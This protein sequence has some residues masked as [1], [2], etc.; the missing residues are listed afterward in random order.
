MPS[1]DVA[2]DTMASNGAK[3]IYPKVCHIYGVLFWVSIFM[4]VS[5]FI[6]YNQP[7]SCI[8]D[9]TRLVFLHPK[10]CG[11]LLVALEASV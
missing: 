1:L 11:G 9:E 5:L 8:R 3:I 10:D 2:I 4:Y 7:L 6:V